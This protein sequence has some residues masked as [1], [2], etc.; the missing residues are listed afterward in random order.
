MDNS[1]FK[2]KTCP[3]LLSSN[4][5]LKSHMKK[6]K[7]I[8]NILT[9]H[10]CFENFNNS[11][12]KCNHLK[13]C[14]AVQPPPGHYL[15]LQNEKNIINNINNNIVNNNQNIII[16]NTNV[17]YNTKL[18]KLLKIEDDTPAEIE[19]IDVPLRK[20][21]SSTLKRLV[22]NTYIGEDIG[23]SKCLCCKLTDITQLSFNCGHIIAVANGGENNIENFKPICQNC[24]SS[25]RTTN[26]EEFILSLQ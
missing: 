22:W 16:N 3:K 11:A 7:G 25:M 24:N 1:K 17:F 14:Y 20:Y 12:S 13:K 6:C 9:C 5:A 26:M 4:F 10:K 2:C 8:E 18:L 19:V 21:I 23:K 15:V